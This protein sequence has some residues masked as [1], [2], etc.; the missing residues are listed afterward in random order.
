MT[1]IQAFV[2]GSAVTATIFAVTILKTGV[3][4]ANRK[5]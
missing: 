1:I 4:T 3:L 5:R 2:L